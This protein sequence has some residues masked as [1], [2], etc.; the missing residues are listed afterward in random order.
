MRFRA[1]VLALVVTALMPWSTPPSV[2]RAEEDPRAS[3][4]RDTAWSPNLPP[5]I[6]LGPTAYFQAPTGDPL[7]VEVSRSDAR[8]ESMA[9][10]ET[11]LAS[12]E[13]RIFE[14]AIA[15]GQVICLRYRYLFS[16]GPGDWTERCTV[17]GWRDEPF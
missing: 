13:E 12:T 5:D 1:L 2:A 8:S 15:S 14:P 17:H 10:W 4:L 9:P 16:D 7:E 6:T 3:R 11:Y